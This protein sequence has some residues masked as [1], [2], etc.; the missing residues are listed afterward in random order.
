MSNAGQSFLSG[1][2]QVGTVYGT[3]AL[4]SNAR[5]RADKP[6]ETRVYGD[7]EVGFPSLA[8]AETRQGMST[9]RSN[10]YPS[11]SSSTLLIECFADNPPVRLDPHQ[12]VTG[13]K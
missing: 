9:G 8:G 10:C 6:S 2:R 3:L 4:E 1:S 13:I 12:Q 11:D 5:Q 7:R